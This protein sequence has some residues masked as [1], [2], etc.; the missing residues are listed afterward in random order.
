[1]DSPSS[2]QRTLWSRDQQSTLRPTP[3]D[4]QSD[5][6]QYDANS[7]SRSSYC[8]QQDDRLKT[9]IFLSTENDIKYD[10]WR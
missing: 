7:R 9:V 1:M 3:T 2:H 5:S 6:R 10:W 4:R 8:V